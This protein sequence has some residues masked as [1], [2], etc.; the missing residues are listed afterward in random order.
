MSNEVLQPGAPVGYVKVTQ[1]GGS[2]EISSRSGRVVSHIGDIVTIK[3]R[4][5]KLLRLSREDVSPE[6]PNGPDLR[7]LLG[8]K[9]DGSR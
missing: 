4:N 1:R 5:G 8:I 2:I 6:Q 9:P 3:T 7:G